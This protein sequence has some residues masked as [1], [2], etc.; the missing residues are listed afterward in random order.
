MNIWDKVF[1]NEPSWFGQEFQK[2]GDLLLFW[3]GHDVPIN[4]SIKMKVTS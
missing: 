1:K 2:H 3:H 4:H